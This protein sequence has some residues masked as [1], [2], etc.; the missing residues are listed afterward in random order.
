MKRNKLL[1]R[2]FSSIIVL[3]VVSA[4]AIPLFAL[5]TSDKVAIVIGNDEI[6]AM[7]E[8]GDV[9]A[10]YELRSST[11]TNITLWDM[12]T[13][14]NEVY[15]VSTTPLTFNMTHAVTYKQSSKN[16]RMYFAGDYSYRMLVSNST[17]YQRFIVS[18]PF[19]YYIEDFDFFFA[20]YYAGIS[21]DQN[22]NCTLTFSTSDYLD[23]FNT[24]V[25][26]TRT[27]G[28]WSNSPA[29]VDYHNNIY[30]YVPN[31]YTFDSSST[32][33]RAAFSSYTFTDLNDQYDRKFS[34]LTITSQANVAHASG[35]SYEYQFIAP[36]L[37]ICDWD[38][39][40]YVDADIADSVEEYLDLITGNPTPNELARINELREE[41]SNSIDNITDA[42]D[43]LSVPMPNL[44]GVSN[45][46]SE[47]TSGMNEATEYAI[48]PIFSINIITVIVGAT[49]I[50]A[51]LKLLL[52]GS[53]PS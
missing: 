37:F 2:I 39:T 52:Y 32:G 30:S 25:S 16:Y 1:K 15:E 27:V 12:E 11:T 18:L 7:F 43:S 10:F 17:L 6:V 33:I 35:T 22:T 45:L 9:T 28:Y 50:F 3:A 49:M 5:D 53:G 19:E 26:G 23:N 31:Q 21:N 14:T 4:T 42:A 44:P 13:G 34:Y 41:F 47:V 38:N 20:P 36:M 48:A 51:V 40:V 46:P 29:I 8:A 24:T